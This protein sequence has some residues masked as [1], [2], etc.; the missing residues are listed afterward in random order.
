MRKPIGP[1]AY[2]CLLAAGCVQASSPIEHV[3]GIAPMAA[4]VSASVDAGQFDAGTFTASDGTVLPY[5]VLRPS[6]LQEG[7]SYPL[8]VQFHGSGGIGTDNAR[9]LDP[10]ARSWALPDLRERYQAYVLVPQ[11]PIRSANYGPASPDQHSEASPA[12]VAAIEL[13][14]AFASKHPVDP[15]RIYATGFSMGGSAAWLA[16]T[17]DPALFAAIAPISGIAPADSRA[18][19]F[20][21]LPVLVFHGNADDENPIT[22]DRRFFAAILKAGGRHIRLREYE[23]LAHSP[24]ADIQPGTAWRDWLFR[25]KRP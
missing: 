4:D 13:V 5:R 19:A 18:P 7:R 12:L 21:T 22:A 10:L 2:L 14:R 16:P 11:F 17:L 25:Q 15:S 23:G 3:A 8:V 1:L 20:R 9:Q 6:R 24:P